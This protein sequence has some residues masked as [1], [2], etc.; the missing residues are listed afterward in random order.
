MKLTF[1]RSAQTLSCSTAPA[2]N[3]SAATKVISLFSALNFWHNFAEEVVFPEPL[4][5]II[6]TT[7]LK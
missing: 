7:F 5:P 2:L 6:I 4:T 3:V 1:V